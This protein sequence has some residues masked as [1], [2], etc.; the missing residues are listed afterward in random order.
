MLSYLIEKSQGSGSTGFLSQAH[1]YREAW[2]IGK[3]AFSR[4]C[5]CYEVRNTSHN[6]IFDNGMNGQQAGSVIPGVPMRISL[7]SVRGGMGS[8][9]T[10]AI[11]DF[12]RAVG[13]KRQCDPMKEDNGRI[14]SSLYRG[15]EL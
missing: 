3:Y 7:V 2:Y 4:A 5:G 6:P 12:I 15:T 10:A 13:R 11:E 1:P 14:M 8:T 9:V